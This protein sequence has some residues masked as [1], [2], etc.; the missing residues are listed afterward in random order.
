MAETVIG[1]GLSQNKLT[2]VNDI[3]Q[4]TAVATFKAVT[5]ALMEDLRSD[6]ET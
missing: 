1:T 3:W 5:L 2:Q 4:N 6:P